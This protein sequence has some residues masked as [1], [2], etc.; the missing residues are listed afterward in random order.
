MNHFLAS[1][2]TEPKI[3]VSTGRGQKQT[4]K[5]L[6]SSCTGQKWSIF[7]NKNNDL[8]VADIM[9]GE[10]GFE[11]ATLCSQ[12]R[13]ATRLRHSPPM[14]AARVAELSVRHA[15]PASATKATDGA[16]LPRRGDESKQSRS[17]RKGAEDRSTNSRAIR[18]T[19][20]AGQRRPA[21]TDDV[22]LPRRR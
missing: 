18:R 1:T 3:G 16:A 13:C 9:V 22:A 17:Q 19:G 8:L 14:R 10:T 2:K 12:S 20:E 7:F 5:N 4:K 6:H 21:A 15:R 11:P